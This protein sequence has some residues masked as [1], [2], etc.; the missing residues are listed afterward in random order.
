[1]ISAQ[2]ALIIG[3][4]GQT[5]GHLLRELLDSPKY[6]RVLEAGR[7]VTPADKLPASARGKLE[8]RVINFEKLDEARLGEGEGFDVVYITL[9][10]TAKLAGSSANFEK[11][12]REYVV[13]AARAAKV[14]DPN[15]PQRL[16]YLCTNVA[17]PKGSSLYQRSKGLTEQ[18]LASLGYADPI[19]FRPGFLRGAKR[20]DF[21][22]LEVVFGP[23]STVLGHFSNNIEIGVDKLAK[24]MRIAGTVGS[25][26]LPASVNATKTSWDKDEFTVV[27][28]ASAVLL[29]KE[30][31]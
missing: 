11:I 9:G 31:L 23:L 24:S 8:Q 25:A 17:D 27:N 4:T 14:A 5:G 3:A 30:N 1:M 18:A 28:N 10:T 13:N 19:I 16:V 22:P 26:G 2:T 12:D 29:A 15:R 20:E 21:R 7:R 6:A